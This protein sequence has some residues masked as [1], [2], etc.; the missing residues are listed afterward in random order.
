MSTDP[1]VLYTSLSFFS[2]ENVCTSV[3]K[4][5]LLHKQPGGTHSFP[6]QDNESVSAYSCL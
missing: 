3:L 4:N 5:L 6:L 2:L 1:N